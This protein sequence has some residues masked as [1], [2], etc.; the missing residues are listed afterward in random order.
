MFASLHFLRSFIHVCKKENIQ[1]VI[2]TYLNIYFQTLISGAEKAQSEYFDCTS[3]L[4]SIQIHSFATT[5]CKI[6]TRRVKYVNDIDLP[7]R[8]L[9]PRR[10][11]PVSGIPIKKDPT[12]LK[13][14]QWPTLLTPI[15]RLASVELTQIHDLIIQL[16]E[17]KN[18]L[19][20]G[21]CNG[22]VSAEALFWWA[23]SVGG[24]HALTDKNCDTAPC[25]LLNN[26]LMPSLG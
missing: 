13:H 16:S 1:F 4:R 12:N 14:K 25:V 20:H 8:V 11:C 2:W 7:N 15:F 17:K 21:L 19:T 18:R 23:D 3:L 9:F 10:S 24:W 5:S 26:N 22:D 6:A